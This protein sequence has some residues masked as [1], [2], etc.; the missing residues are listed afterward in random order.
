MKILEQK[1]RLS[2]QRNLWLKITL[3][4]LGVSILLSVYFSI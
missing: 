1:A 4:L 3:I 2:K